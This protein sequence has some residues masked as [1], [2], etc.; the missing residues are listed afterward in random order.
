M[1]H[2]SDIKANWFRALLPRI[3][4]QM[5]LPTT[6]GSLAARM[7]VRRETTHGLKLPYVQL[8]SKSVR[9]NPVKPTGLIQ[10]PGCG[11]MH[12]STER[13]G[14]AAEYDRPAM[15]STHCNPLPIL[16]K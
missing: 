8:S 13:C 4:A 11:S 5:A 6:R 1:L 15:N 12:E 3:K 9:S 2:G 10:R 14:S 7:E 16:P